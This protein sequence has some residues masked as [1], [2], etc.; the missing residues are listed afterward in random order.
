MYFEKRIKNS[1][2]QEI[3]SK[4]HIKLEKYI[5]NEEYCGYDPYDALTSDLFKFPF[6]KNNKLFRFSF[7][8]IVR[9]SPLNLRKIL[10]IKKRLNPVT[11]GLCI[12]AYSYMWKIS[13]CNKGFYENEI[14]LLISKLIENQSNGYHGISWGY[15]FDWEGRYFTVPAYAPTVVT[16]GI[17]SNA[18]YV[19]YKITNNQKSFELCKNTVSF[20]SNDLNR[21]IKDENFCFSY[22][23]F[24]KQVVFNATMKG[25]RLLSQVYSLTNDVKLKEDASKTV[26][27]VMDH[28]FED[29]SWQ[30]SYG[31]KRT[32]VDNY[33]TGYILDSLDDYIKLTQDNKYQDNLKKGLDYYTKNFFHDNQIPKFYDKKL[34]PI[35]CTSASQSILTL[36]RFGE[37]ELATNVALWIIKNMQSKKGFFHYRKSK[38]YTV[39]TSFMRWSNA[40]MFLALSFLLYKTGTNK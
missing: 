19:N 39:K 3:L 38:S 8:Q 6:I 1:M 2:N 25:A 28:Q 21:I 7:Q 37:I 36:C 33:H 4:S 32:W 34:F 11:I 5:L 16:T 18:L 12:Q 22:S 35:D 20:I 26:S 30:Y 29:G 9:R 40:W 24:D 13:P 23:P 10:F 15:D 17:I 14:N 31:D 27:F